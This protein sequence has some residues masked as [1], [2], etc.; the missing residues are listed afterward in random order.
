MCPPM[1][2]IIAQYKDENETKKKRNKIKNAM[3]CKCNF[4][5]LQLI[6]LCR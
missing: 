6:T 1:T 2:D 5:P 3:E 4:A